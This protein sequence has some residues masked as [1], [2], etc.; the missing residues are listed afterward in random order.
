MRWGLYIFMFIAFFYLAYTVIQRVLVWR[1]GQPELRTDYPEKR[2]LAVFKYV[3]LQAKILRESFAGIMHAALFFGFVALAGVTFF[4]FIKD[5]FTE[6]FFHWNFITGNFYLIW[7]LVADLAGAVVLVGLGM[8]VY[9]RYVTKPTRLDTK[10]I[11]TFA[12]VLIFIIIISGFTSEAMR[13][14][15]QNFPEWEVWSPF[16]YV[17]AY[18]FSLFSDS[19]LRVMHQ[20]SWW[21]HMLGAFIFIGLVGSDKLG[22]VVISS[23]NVYYGN[24]NNES[25]QTK[26]ALNVIDP[27]VFEVAESFGVSKVEEYTWKQLMDSDA[28]TRCG[29]CQDNC[30][31]WLTEKPLS[32]K[33]LVNDIKANMDERIPK[34]RL[35]EDPATVETTPLIEGSV[36]A[37]EFWSCTNCSACQEA[38]PVNIEHVQKMIDLRRY[39]VLMEG[40]MAPELQTSFMNLENNFNPYGFAFGERGAWLPADLGVKTMAEDSQVDYLYFVGSAASYDKRNQKVATAFLKILQ[41]AGVKAGILGAEEADSGDAALRGGN[42]YLF[43]ALATQNLENFKAY[44]VKKIVCTCPHD[45]NVIKKEYKKFAKVGKNAEGGPLEANYEVYHHTEVINELIKSGKI[46]LV[47]ALNETVTYHDS[48]FLGR[49]NEIYEAPR[50]ILKAIPGV[51]FVEMSRNHRTSFCCGA[52]GARMFIEEHLGT[53]INQFRTKDAQST[54][55]TKVCTAC[56]FCMTM[57]SDGIT[58]LDIQNMENY[59]IAEYVFNAMEK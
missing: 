50:E 34:L 4:I 3:I 56:P 29:R 51:N 35:A 2:I 43:H 24:L 9:R 5:D 54:G 26:Y 40:D 13:I 55:A 48:C 41:K 18:F 42:E 59:D 37:D 30:P 25:A 16:G 22:H 53:R 21:I 1:K 11:D 39:K 14:A 46:K 8:A 47:N 57:L 38:C 33:K 28:C 7:S 52:G 10:P 12:L 32:P 36:L 20:F 23:L 44:G 17:L 45:Y 15:M 27:A 19:T 6:L 58:E 49:Y 31:A